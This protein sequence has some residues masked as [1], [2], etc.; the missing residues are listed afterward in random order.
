MKLNKENKTNLKHLIIS[1][2]SAIIITLAAL[3][4]IAV[5]MHFAEI[6][7]N[8]SAPLSSVGVA[9]GCFFGGFIYSKL[10]AQKGLICGF[11][12][13]IIYFV[14]ITIISLILSAKNI[15]VL[16]L[17]HLIIM[18]LSGGIGGILGVNLNKKI[19]I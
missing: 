11:T 15:S 9:I 4:L 1:A 19:K 17:I 14:L 13:A 7:S 10:R 18:L 5:L 2:F 8:Y 3:F 6:G 16:T 12:I